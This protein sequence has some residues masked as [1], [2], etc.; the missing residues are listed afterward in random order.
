[1]KKPSKIFFKSNLETTQ[2]YMYNI[3]CQGHQSGLNQPVPLQGLEASW[4]D[5]WGSRNFEANFHCIASRRDKNNHCHSMVALASLAPLFI[6]LF[7]FSFL[8]YQGILLEYFSNTGLVHA[9]HQLYTF[10]LLL[11]FIKV[12]LAW[13]GKFWQP[14]GT[15]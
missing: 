3:Y 8:V 5:I 14:L 2:K 11:D 13:S 15:S 1:M 7:C 6:A 9:F 4:K 12:S 10:I